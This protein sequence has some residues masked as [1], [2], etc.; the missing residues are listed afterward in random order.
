MIRA[1]VL[2]WAGTAVDHGCLAPVGVF[3]DVFARHGVAVSVA[4]ARGP[5]GTHK[6]EHLRRMCADPAIAARWR[7]A[8][9]S[10]P[11]EANVDQM[12]A[13]IEPL[14]LEAL[15]RYARPVPGLLA[16]VAELDRRGIR[17]GTTTGYNRAMLDVLLHA[18]AAHGYR[19]EVAIPSSEVPEGRPAP[20]LA[21]RA[22][23]A[24]RVYPPAAAVH[25]G[26]TVVDVHAGRNAGMWSVAVASTGNLVGWSEAELA[27]ADPAERA[28][29]LAS[30]RRTLY[31][32][33]A[34]LVID[35][36]ADLAEAIDH[37]EARGRRGP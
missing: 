12:Y 13:E 32:A 9:G 33:G 8:N 18:A 28:A 1:V 29:R 27:E 26:D 4:E 6:R 7:E 3:V 15:P 17:L 21:W 10:A 31:E 16:A 14:A 22:L 25:V 5:M 35:S 11:T 19:P 37:L 30:A 34:D 23:E 20:F 24:L 36:V 2:D